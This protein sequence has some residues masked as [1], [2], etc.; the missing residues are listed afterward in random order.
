MFLLGTV[1][2]SEL[3]VPDS[4]G[5]S[6]TLDCRQQVAFPEWSSF[7]DTVSDWWSTRGEVYMAK[8]VQERL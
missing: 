7:R 3:I 6:A 8:D 4:H 2:I 1:Q 5:A